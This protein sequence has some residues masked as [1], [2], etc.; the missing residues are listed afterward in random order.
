MHSVKTS[1]LGLWMVLAVL[2]LALPGCGGDKITKANF[3]QI[4]PG[5]SQAEVE[6]IVGTGTTPQG[7]SVNLSMG[8]M[9]MNAKVVR[10]GDDKKNITIVYQEGKVSSFPPPVASGL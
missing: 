7:S 9:T 2:C 10:Y 3:D 5:M 6:A 1:R 4:K 8:G